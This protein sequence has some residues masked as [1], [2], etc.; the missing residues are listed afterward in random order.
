MILTAV[1]NYKNVQQE[2][3]AVL[4]TETALPAVDTD[5]MRKPE[6]I[7]VQA[8]SKNG[9]SVFIGKTGLAADGSTGAYELGPGQGMFLPGHMIDDWFAIVED[10]TGTPR[11][12]VS[13][14]QGGF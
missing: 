9:V 11:L 5:I 8:W 2:S 3:L 1:A 6:K 12:F 10:D 13:Y 4:E 14:L 7:F